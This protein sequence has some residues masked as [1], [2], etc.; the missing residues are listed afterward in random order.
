MPILN[1]TVVQLAN[2]GIA[3]V[4]DLLDFD[5]ESLRQ[6]ADNL[7]RPGGRVPDPTPGAPSGVSIPQPPYVFGAKLQMRL[8]VACKLV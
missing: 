2:E 3:T 7:R 6:I 8:E 4:A 1:A 5:K